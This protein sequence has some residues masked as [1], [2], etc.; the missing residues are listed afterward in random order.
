MLVGRIKDAAQM[1]SI[2]AHTAAAGLDFEQDLAD[3]K[4]HLD[5]AAWST[6]QH[7]RGCLERLEAKEAAAQ[8]H[9]ERV[10]QI[11]RSMTIN[12]VAEHLDEFFNP[13]GGFVYLL[14]GEDPNTPL[15]V[16]QSTNILS[17][18]GAHMG[19][20]TKRALVKRVQLIRCST[21]KLA[22]TEWRLIQH[23]QPPLNV[24]GCSRTGRLG[25]SGIGHD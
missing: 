1:A 15:Y 16:G 3:L 4:S 6:D 22:D 25:E 23:Y 2:I 5:R 24:V 7:L 17:R 18:L 11:K 10:E 13:H 9:S 19:D 14:W 12:V 8:A 21:E 20:K